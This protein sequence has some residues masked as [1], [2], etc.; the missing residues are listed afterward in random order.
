[1][2]LRAYYCFILGFVFGFGLASPNGMF[3]TSFAVFVSPL[4][5]NKTCPTVHVCVEPL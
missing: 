5:F 2:T 1:M 4:Y 3:A